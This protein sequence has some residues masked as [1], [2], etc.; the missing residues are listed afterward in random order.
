MQILLSKI[1]SIPFRKS[2]DRLS[3]QELP[4][5][6]MFQLRSIVKQLREEMAKWDDMQGEL[7]KKWATKDEFGNPII[8]KRDGTTS[9]YKMD[10]ESMIQFAAA[11]GELAK[12]EIDLPVVKV[13][14]LGGAV[15]LTVDD[16]VELEFI[17]DGVEEEAPKKKKK[18]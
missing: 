16:L 6:A 8:E 11:M 17:V 14:D 7:A 1:V 5:K 12:V 10:T 3:A 13:E 9:Y 18:K 15:K 4:I 2:L